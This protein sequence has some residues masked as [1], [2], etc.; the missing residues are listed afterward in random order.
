MVD[1]AERRGI[2]IDQTKL[3]TMLRVPVVPVVARTGKGCDQVEHMLL[4]KATE[5]TEPLTL[6]MVGRWN[7]QSNAFVPHGERRRNFLSVG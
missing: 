1:V 7:E 6:F 3:A 2:F 5:Q 4:E